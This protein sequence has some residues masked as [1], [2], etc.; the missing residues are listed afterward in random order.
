MWSIIMKMKLDILEM[1]IKI[2][3]IIF[4]AKDFVL[5]EMWSPWI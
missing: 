2:I 3:K 5:L 4:G 1:N